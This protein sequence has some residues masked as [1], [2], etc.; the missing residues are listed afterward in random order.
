MLLLS[1]PGVSVVE[2]GESADSGSA[3]EVAATGRP[4]VSVVPPG[5]TCSAP[6][7]GPSVVSIAIP[8]EEEA[9]V[10]RRERVR[11]NVVALDGG[12]IGYGRGE[13]PV[14]PAAR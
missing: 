2:A 5:P 10:R 3:V 4:P 7:A 14:A 12:G 11:P 6:V 8:S 1:S 13:P 9:A